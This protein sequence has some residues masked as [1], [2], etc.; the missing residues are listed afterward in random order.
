MEKAKSLFAK[1]GYKKVTMI[2]IAEVAEVS[3]PTLYALFPDKDAVFSAC[4]YSHIEDFRIDFKTRAE[5]TKSSEGKLQALFDIYVI[6]PFKMYYPSKDA[7]DMLNNATTYAPKEMDV[8]WGDFEKALHQTLTDGHKKRSSQSKDIARV[9]ACFA[10]D[11]RSTAKDAKDLTKL[12]R[13]AIEM[14]LR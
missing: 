14:A 7:L 9:L 11:A 3:R 4:I 1:M 5:K 6:E 8:Y 10:R 13:T 2:D 12:V